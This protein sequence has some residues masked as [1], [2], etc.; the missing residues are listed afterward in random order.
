LVGIPSLASNYLR[1]FPPWLADEYPKA[2]RI[3]VLRSA[4][5][6]FARQ[7]GRGIQ[8]SAQESGHSVELVPFEAPFHNDDAALS[9]LVQTRAEAIVLAGSFL[10]ELAIMQ[11]RPCWPTTVCAVA[12]VGAGIAGFAS[13]L[14]RMAEGVLGP[15]QWEPGVSSPTTVGPTSDWFL[16]SFQKQF[17]AMPDYVAAGSFATGL[18]VSE[19]IRQAASLDG[20]T[21]R[22]VASQLNCNSLYG[23]FRIDPQSGKQLGH[24]VLLIR[25]QNGT[26]T[27]LS[28]RQWITS[29]SQ[30]TQNMGSVAP[31]K[32]RVLHQNGVSNIVTARPLFYAVENR[33]P[34]VDKSPYHSLILKKAN[35]KRTVA[36]WSDSFS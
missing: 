2:R 5:G 14:G 10:D 17:G 22:R 26:K 9:V 8:E 31:I 13:R 21:L 27:L 25:W 34:V 4:K 16:N 19:C 11:T 28:T 15:S 36:T 20:E 30:F 7:V 18:I 3:C 23:R 29:E 24:R 35:R 12:A 32:S 1:A 33:S 6:S